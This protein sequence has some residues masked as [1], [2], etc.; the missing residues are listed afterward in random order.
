MT[1]SA[2]LAFGRLAD[3]GGNRF[4]D[5]NGNGTMEPHETPGRPVCV[6]VAVLC[7]VNRTAGRSLT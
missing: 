7:C 2:C 4:R 1:R 3:P 5:R 6:R